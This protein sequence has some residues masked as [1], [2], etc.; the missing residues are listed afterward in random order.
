MEL[1]ARNNLV[2]FYDRG[3]PRRESSHSTDRKV[4]EKLKKRLAEVETKTYIPRENIRVDELVPPRRSLG[5]VFGQS[6]P[7]S[8]HVRISR[9]TVPLPN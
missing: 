3:I 1:T 9:Q 7:E 8:G 6:A 4:V 2:K 5:R